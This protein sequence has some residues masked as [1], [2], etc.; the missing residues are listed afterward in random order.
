MMLF[1]LLALR[2]LTTSCSFFHFYA[3]AYAAA[4]FFNM[5]C[6][7][8]DSWRRYAAT[9]LLFAASAAIFVTMPLRCHALLLMLLPFT[10]LRYTRLLLPDFHADLR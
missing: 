7:S 8:F 10:R 5:P 2:S 6:Q 3:A 1:Q 9:L 4:A